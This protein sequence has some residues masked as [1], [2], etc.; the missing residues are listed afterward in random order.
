MIDFP[1]LSLEAS[2]QAIHILKFYSTIARLCFSRPSGLRVH[3]IGKQHAPIFLRTFQEIPSIHSLYRFIPA[4]TTLSN[5][6][7][8]H[9][10]PNHPLFFPDVSPPTTGAVMVTFTP[11]GCFLNMQ[12]HSFKLGTNTGSC[13]SEHNMSGQESVVGS[14]RV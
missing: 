1:H 5:H 8:T 6:P 9:H 3:T 12:T 4:F 10:K 7:P 13:G 14:V 2:V 11:P